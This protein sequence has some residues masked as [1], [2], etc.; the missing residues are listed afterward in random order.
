MT[1]LSRISDAAFN[2]FV[3]GRLSGKAERDVVAALEGDPASAARAAAWRRHGDALRAAY[4]P[5]A[6]EPLPL[7]MLL[8]LRASFPDRPWTRTS[9]LVAMA[10]AAGT[11]AGFI[12]GWVAL[13]IH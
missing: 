8:K 13:Q 6:D 7:S 1:T 10:F 12:L 11:V 2:A 9:S 4:G 3:D 5:L